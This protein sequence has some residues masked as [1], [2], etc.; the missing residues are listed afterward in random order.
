MGN[1][2]T[3][4]NFR[5]PLLPET[6]DP[7]CDR[8]CL[9]TNTLKR[10]QRLMQHVAKKA[11][12]YFTGYLQK[13][14]PLG[15][16]ELQQAAKHLSYLDIT[17]A[18]GA[19]AKHYRKVLHRVCG[20]L[21]FRCSARPLTEE[22]MLASFW[23]GD[24]P[25][26]AECIRSFAVVPF[27]GS[28]WLAQYDKATEVR[29][30]VKPIH[31]RQAQLKGSDLYG[32]RGQD[33]RLRYLSPWEFT[34]LWEVQR[35]QPPLQQASDLISEWLPGCGAGPEPADG[36]Q[37]GRDY[38]WKQPILTDSTKHIIP[39]PHRASTAAGADHYF[40]R[41]AAPLVPYPTACPLRKVDMSPD[42]QA[43]LLNIYLRPW[44]L[45][46]DEATLHVPHIQALD[47]PISERQKKSSHR[48]VGK[49]SV[50]HRSHNAAWKDYIIYISQHIVSANAA[51]T[52]SN[53]LAAT[54]CSPDDVEE[55][56]VE[57]GTKP[58]REVDT[59]W[60]DMTTVQRLTA[61][62]GFQYSKRSAQTAQSL[63]HDWTTPQ[64][65]T[66]HQGTQ[67][68]S[69]GLPDPGP[70]PATGAAG[71]DPFAQQTQPPRPVAMNYG[72]FRLDAARTWLQALNQPGLT[73]APNQQQK[74][75]L[76]A[77][78]ERCHAEAVEERADKQTRSEPFRAIL[79][80]VPGA[81]KSLTNLALASHVFR[82]GM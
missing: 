14:Q 63:V 57:A 37:F 82:N 77:V 52:I 56:H 26:S 79:H 29:H 54:E 43:R 70:A 76:T 71:T 65:S 80:G 2:H 48:C 66:N 16:K 46:C 35:L 75:V 72:T 13:P 1:S 42:Q 53:F 23:D 60:V 9:E 22:V 61:G 73:P 20:D 41:R 50:G 32:W 67:Q 74:Q 69:T 10:L 36:W 40:V 6:H 19:E 7:A 58:D 3:G 33:P 38:R 27:V 18:K 45:A 49:T 47:M 4:V 25:T 11:T 59:S 34:A 12:Q 30:C 24:D 62:E 21:E 5:V 78:V 28:D 8:N 31:H 39:L 44:T 64:T 68:F 15:R 51:R 81:G 55:A 17:P